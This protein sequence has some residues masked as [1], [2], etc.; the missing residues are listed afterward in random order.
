MAGKFVAYTGKD[1]KH[2]FRLKAGNGQ[3]ILAS[4]TYADKSGAS[5]GI[6]SVMKNA[7]DGA[8]ERKTAKDGSPFFNMKAGNGQ[9]I[10]KS[11]MYAS[12]SAMENGI[13]SVIANAPDAEIKDITEA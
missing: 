10:G 7:N 1:K 11:Q 6:Q 13:A 12:E 9:I 8:F 2:Y 5:N 3:I 4:Q